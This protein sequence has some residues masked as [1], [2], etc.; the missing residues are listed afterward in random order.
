MSIIVSTPEQICSGPVNTSQSKYLW[1]F[2]RADRFANGMGNLASSYTTCTTL[3]D[4]L[5][6]R[7]AT[8]F[9]NLPSVFDKRGTGFG[10]GTKGD[11]TSFAKNSPPPNAYKVKS[12]FDS[13]RGFTFGQSRSVC[14]HQPG[15]TINSKRV[16]VS[17]VQA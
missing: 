5:H 2:P 8:G 16:Q 13:T 7:S 14:Y 9:Y 17:F 6:H 15:L 10:Y 11:F 12:E 3:A 1:T 4:S